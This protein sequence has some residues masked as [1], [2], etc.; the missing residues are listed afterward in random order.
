[1]TISVYTLLPALSDHFL[2]VDSRSAITGTKGRNFSQALNHVATL[3]FRSIGTISK[4][5]CPGTEWSLPALERAT[6]GRI[7]IRIS[8]LGNHT[9]F[10]LLPHLSVFIY[11]LFFCSN[12]RTSPGKIPDWLH[13]AQSQQQR[14]LRP[15]LGQS[16]Q[17]EGSVLPGIWLPKWHRRPSEMPQGKSDTW[18]K[19]RYLTWSDTLEIRFFVL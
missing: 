3:L 12:F 17:V 6:S 16:C 1:M 10:R 4:W 18:G 13:S 11:L 14:E 5:D 7:W 2:W 15:C 9:D 8:R 19:S